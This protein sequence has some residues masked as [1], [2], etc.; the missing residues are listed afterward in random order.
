MIKFL[1]IIILF[2]LIIIYFIFE[3]YH[4]YYIIIYICLLLFTIYKIFFMYKFTDKK[5]TIK[6][7]FI[8]VL[9]YPSIYFLI[10]DPNPFYYLLTFYLPFQNF[11]RG[12]FTIMIITYIISRILPGGFSQY[13]LLSEQINIDVGE[14]IESGLKNSDSNNNESYNNSIKENINKNSINDEIKEKETNINNNDKI[15]NFNDN[16]FFLSNL[17]F[18]LK[19]NKIYILIIII[20]LTLIN[21]ILTLYRM[22]LWIYFNKK[23]KVLP[24]STS[25]NTTYY[26]ASMIAN[27]E[28]IIEDWIKEMKKIINYLGEKNVMLSIIEN[29][30]SKDNTRE[31]LIKFK[32]Y[33]D[34]NNIRNK[35]II[36]HLIDDPRKK[37]FNNDINYIRYNRILFYSQLRNK[38]LDLL[39]ETK[40]IDFNNTKIVYFNDIIFAYEDIIKLISTNNENY[41]TVCGLDFNIYFYDT[42]VSYDLDGNGLRHGYPYFINSEGQEQLINLKPIRIFSCWNGV[43]VF[44]AAPLE[45]KKLQFRVENYTPTIQYPLNSYQQRSFESECTYIHIDMENLGYTKRLLNPD[46][47]FAYEY[48]YYYLTKYLG[49]W[50]YNI[51]FYFYFYFYRFS[52]KRNKYMSNIK[53]KSVRLGFGERL[54]RWFNYHK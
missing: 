31:Y 34:N 10:C 45:N 19:E 52:E 20:I 8:L 50:T 22:K 54:E 14:N 44:T 15:S 46:V 42:W 18:K 41:D 5:L 25:K 23:E 13:R 1:D 16:Y 11:F 32:D 7:I 12:I 53:D 35:I 39:Y 48:K 6:H 26:L 3:D 37:I 49:H 2:I 27:S 36:E 28:N 4:I 21:I 30:D 29:G 24:I 17:V 38:A 9:I 33:L 47:K 40:D 51:I 43:M